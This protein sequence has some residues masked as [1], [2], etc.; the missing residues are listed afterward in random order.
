METKEYDEGMLTMEDRYEGEFQERRAYNREWL[1][2]HALKEDDVMED[3][4]G[5]YVYL[6][7]EDGLKKTYLPYSNV[8]DL[9]F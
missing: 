7:N 6:E 8:I 3:V 5:E 9:A 1:N 2:D 4:Q